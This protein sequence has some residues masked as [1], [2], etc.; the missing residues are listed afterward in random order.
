MRDGQQQLNEC[1]Q[2]I[3]QCIVA[4]ETENAK[5]DVVPTE[6]GLEHREA[7]GNALQFQSIHLI[8]RHLTQSQDA[9]PYT[10]GE[11][12]QLNISSVLLSHPEMSP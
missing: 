10:R 9:V 2:G 12:R 11:Q 1:L 6:D 4:I 5:V 3:V 8:L 7:D